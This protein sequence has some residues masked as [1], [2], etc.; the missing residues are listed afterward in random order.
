MARSTGSNYDVFISYRRENGAETAKHLRDVLT[1]RGY[2]VFFDTDS[3]RSGNF[4]TQLYGV[5]DGCTDF[6]LVL[7]PGALDRCVN[8]GDWVRQELSYALSGNKNVIPILSGGFRFPDTLPPDIEWVRW[9]NGIA[10]NVE[11]FDA[12]IEKLETFMHSKPVRRRVPLLPICLG[13]AVVALAAALVPLVLGRLPGGDAASGGGAASGGS[14]TSDSSAVSDKTDTSSG[15]VRYTPENGYTS[16]DDG[17]ASV[18][19]TGTSYVMG[20]PFEV[21]NPENGEVEYTIAI[22]G[23]HILPAE[24]EK[25]MWEEYDPDA[26]DLLAVQCSIEN[27]G[28]HRGDE[29]EIS[30]YKI[31]QDYTVVIKD[32]NGYQLTGVMAIYHGTDGLY[33]CECTSSIPV[34]SKGRF[35]LIFYMEKGTDEVTVVLDSHAGRVAT[36]PVEL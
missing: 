22:D 23:I 29:G 11:Y 28:Y 26:V 7:S 10:V 13:V 8:E 12:M 5:I 27:Y 20:E 24:F 36:V 4:N 32:P 14:A 18:E 33:V 21:C 19:R 25:N 1:E 17:A 3:L 31:Q 6:I 16:N 30:L 35:C 9:R 34:D 2:R 15:S